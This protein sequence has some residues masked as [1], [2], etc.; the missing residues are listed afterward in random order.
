MRA[1]TASL[2]LSQTEARQQPNRVWTFLDPTILVRDL[3]APSARWTS[4]PGG[5]VTGDQAQVEWQAS[6]NFGSDGIGQQR[7]GVGGRAPLRRGARARAR[8]RPPQP[9][10]GTR[11]R[12]DAPPRGRR[13]RHRRRGLPGCDPSNR[14]HPAV[15]EHHPHRPARRRRARDGLGRRRHERGARLDPA[16]PRTGRADGRLLDDRRRDV[17][18]S[19][20]SAYAAPARRSASSSTASDNAG[21]SRE[22]TS[23]L[24]TRPSAAIGGAPTTTIVGGDG[25]ARGA[26]ADRGERGAAARTSPASRRA[27]IRTNQARSYSRSGR[28]LVPLIASTY[29]RPVTISGRFLHPNG[30]GLRGA[31][32]YLRRPEGL[33]ARRRRSP[34]VAGASPSR[35][36][37]AGAEPGARSRSGGRWW[38]RPAVIQLRPLVTTRISARSIRPGETLRISGV[39]S[40]R[41][42][43]RGKL[44]KLEWRQGGT[45]RPLALATAD[46]R[47]R[48]VLAYRFSA[49]AGA[50]HHP[51][52]RRRPSREG[53]AL[54]SGGCNSRRCP[55]GLKPA[56][57]RARPN[58]SI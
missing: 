14:S 39:I 48:Y 30:R 38:S 2:R 32:V 44:V 10:G 33:H 56:T 8:S 15:G 9:G 3:E 54:P 12:P 22:V 52:A 43:G 37:R 28:L 21:L 13:R 41:G 11:R 16:R 5:W 18:T 27:A 23:A 7:I 4:V 57:W 36:A 24:V 17:G 6:D 29:S 45:W 55:S 58:P 20:S 46:R 50:V 42:A 1:L 49:G 47:G 31:T 35:C 25:P 26:R 51:A 40:P 53:L 19:T 34:T